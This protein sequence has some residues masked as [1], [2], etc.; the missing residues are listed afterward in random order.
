MKRVILPSLFRQVILVSLGSASSVGIP[1]FNRK[2]SLERGQAPLPVI[3]RY[4]VNIAHQAFDPWS[5][6]FWRRMD[7]LTGR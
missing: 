3:D 2:L 4:L 5:H 7:Q 6:L 1:A